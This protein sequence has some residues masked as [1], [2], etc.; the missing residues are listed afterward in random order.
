MKR[1]LNILTRG[2]N[3]LDRTEKGSY[4]PYG[5]LRGTYGRG[6][7]GD[8]PICLV[9]QFDAL[10]AAAL[11]LTADLNTLLGGTG[12]ETIARDDGGGVLLGTDANDGDTCFLKPAAATTLLAWKIAASGARFETVVKTPAA[13]VL[14]SVMFG[15]IGLNENVTD[16]DPSG[17]AGDG[18]MFCFSVDNTGD[19]VTGLTEA[20][21][22]NWIL[23]TKVDGTDAWLPTT[24]PVVAEREY[25]LRIEI[26]ADL[27]PEFYINGELVGK[28]ATALTVGDTVQTFAG[29]EATEAGSVSLAIRFLK[30]GRWLG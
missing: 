16:P 28:G 14:Q 20:Q 11:A 5:A 26:G 25:D 9:D 21:H 7:R 18:A 22:K 4:E 15:S 8:P 12:T 2:L 29:I 19:L 23:H 30:L 6:L 3:G 27:K 10:P 17:T 24:V 13:T 1:F